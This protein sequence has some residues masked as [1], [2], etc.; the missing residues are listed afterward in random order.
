MT[1]TWRRRVTSPSNHNDWFKNGHMTQAG[2]TGMTQ[3]QQQQKTV[4]IHTKLKL[5]AR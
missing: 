1:L 4:C 3:Q 2:L 5:G